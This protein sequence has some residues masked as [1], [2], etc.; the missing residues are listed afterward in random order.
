MRRHARAALALAA[1]VTSGCDLLVGGE[2]CEVVLDELGLPECS[3]EQAGVLENPMV[4]LGYEI[5][6]GAPLSHGS[7]GTVA[8]L[9]GAT[10][11]LDVGGRSI[12]F[13]WHGAL[14]NPVFPGQQV[15]VSPGDTEDVLSTEEHQWVVVKPYSE[16]RPDRTYNLGG[17]ELCIDQFFGCLAN[18]ELFGLDFQIRSHFSQTT[19]ST[20]ETGRVGNWMVSNLGVS[21]FSPDSCATEAPPDVITGHLL[22]WT[23]DTADDPGAMQS[24]SDEVKGANAAFPYYEVYGFYGER[25]AGEGRATILSVADGTTTLRNEDGFEFIFAWPGELP[26]KLREGEEVGYSIDPWGWSGLHLEG[27]DLLVR[28]S[29]GFSVDTRTTHLPDGPSVRY[30][31]TCGLG[32]SSHGV[33]AIAE[34]EGSVVELSPGTEGYLA[35]WAIRQFSGYS[36]PPYTCDGMN[37]EGMGYALTTAVRDGSARPLP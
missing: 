8:A 21:Y 3:P 5:P 34:W 12:A 18:G 9:D 16:G 1:L 37:A 20:G 28:Q 10:L 4:G 14:P 27:K 17:P 31:P 30:G 26:S 22:A 29:R 25:E 35:G 7:M 32:P 19:V 24:C 23:V 6:D 13:H 2:D 15:V 11:H 36:S 33:S